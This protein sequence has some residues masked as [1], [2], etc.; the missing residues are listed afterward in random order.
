MTEIDRERAAPP[1]SGTSGNE[2][3]KRQS[4]MER[5]EKAKQH[6]RVTL[7]YSPLNTRP[8]L[9]LGKINHYFL[10]K[11]KRSEHHYLKCI[12]YCMSFFFFFLSPKIMCGLIHRAKDEKQKEAEEKE[13]MLEQDMPESNA[14]E[15]KD[16][17]PEN[18]KKKIEWEKM[19]LTM[20]N[21]HEYIES[22]QELE[23]L[24]ECI[25]IE[26]SA[27]KLLIDLILTH[28]HKKRWQQCAVHA[29]RMIELHKTHFDGYVQM[30]N[31]YHHLEKPDKAQE[32]ANKA[33]EIAKALDEKNH[34]GANRQLLSLSDQI[35]QKNCEDAVR[36]QIQTRE[37]EKKPIYVIIVTV[38]CFFFCF[39]FLESILN[40][41]ASNIFKSV[42]VY[43]TKKQIMDDKCGRN[44]EPICLFLFLFCL[45][46]SCL[47][48]SIFYYRIFI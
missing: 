16:N 35:Q 29:K 44:F 19:E 3:R 15:N 34:T 20:D 42:W 10:N 39:F 8:H 11:A 37:G 5:I 46:K 13:L 40:Q 32:Y 48:N 28:F 14:Q 18:L 7:R 25:R 47:L 1:L 12:E 27:H 6:Y 38:F 30:T 31:V 45:C 43:T 2:V 33:L 22:A 23:A 41:S 4:Q 17:S 36:E 9:G 26:I 21:L 24:Q